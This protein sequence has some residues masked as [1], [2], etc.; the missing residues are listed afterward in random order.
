[1][2][3]LLWLARLLM[4]RPG[5]GRVMLFLYPFTLIA[6]FG[7]SIGQVS[8]DALFFKLYGMEY[9]PH[10]YALIAV[11]LVPASLAYAAFVDRLTPHRLFVYMLVGVCATVGLAWLL[12]NPVVTAPIIGPRTMQQLEDSLKVPDLKLDEKTL[13]KL[14]DIFPGPGGEA[15]EAYAW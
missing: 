5:E 6:G 15:P 11:V 4:L 3:L 2:K 7:L 13:A 10:M 12:H 1:M 8:S 14:D 9:L